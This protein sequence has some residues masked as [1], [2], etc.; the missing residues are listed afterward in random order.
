MKHLTTL[1]LT[2]LVLGG[3][4]VVYP[5]GSWNCYLEQIKESKNPFDDDYSWAEASQI[6]LNLDTKIYQYKSG[7]SYFAGRVNPELTIEEHKEVARKLDVE[8][9]KN[10]IVSED[11]NLFVVFKVGTPYVD[12]FTDLIIRRDGPD[13]KKG[14]IYESGKR[15]PCDFERY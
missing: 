8:I 10:L 2:L 12:D 9:L 7:S 4:D 15:Y 3:C 11:N 1:L 14:T 5:N 6:I 13:S